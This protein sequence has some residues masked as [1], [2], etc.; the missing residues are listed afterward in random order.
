MSDFDSAHDR[1]LAPILIVDDSAT[2]RHFLI[3]S[4]APLADIE[5]IE[6]D[7]VTSAVERLQERI[8]AL[9]IFDVELPDGKGYDI[10]R[11]LRQNNQSPTPIIFITA[12]SLSSDQ[13][14]NAYE[15]GAVDFIHKPLQAEILRAKVRVFCDL[16]WQRHE[17]EVRGQELA[18]LS[19]TSKSASQAKSA[20]LANM[21]HE[22]RTPLN[23]I[24]GT[25]ELL[26]DTTLDPVQR[27]YVDIIVSS[28][29]SLL[30]I[31]ND[32]LDLSKIEAG[33]TKVAPAHIKMN[34]FIKSCADPVI[35]KAEQKE[36]EF[37][38]YIQPDAPSDFVADPV[39]LRQIVVNLL[40]NAVKFTKQG[41][42][43]LN[44]SVPSENR[45][46]FVVND[47]GI[48]IPND[49]LDEIFD[50]FSQA[51]ISTTRKFGGTG[52]GLAIT[53]HLTDMMGG[54]LGVTSTLGQGST[55]WIEIPS[56]FLQPNEENNKP[57]A[58]TENFSPNSINFHVLVVEDDEVNRIIA[59]RSLEKLGCRVDIAHHGLEGLEASRKL[60]YDIIFMDC[61]M[62]TM[63]GYQATGLI[64]E[65][66]NPNVKTPII[67]LTANVL[68]GAKQKCLDAGM[69]DYVSKPF[70]L[71]D[72]QAILEKYP[73]KD[74]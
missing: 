45:L 29:E 11:H 18:E 36:I 60:Q 51:D 24:I 44:V 58:N 63:D 52:L 13:I 3:E 38:L 25:A 72:L 67:A 27:R 23:G 12:A 73:K 56:T 65:H 61:M 68:D 14:K 46:R 37:V 49:K 71:R 32:I 30:T 5:L 4:L 20:F 8:Y 28:G 33:R 7:S 35:I 2:S 47:T 74:A 55:F 31:I 48:G 42:V 10:A 53:R 15:L 57:T 40:S 69:T 64:R 54:T 21:S 16:F 43:M 19:S 41:H 17:L 34:E 22:I 59:T 62:P 6:A 9:A 39:L 70:R 26:Q 1:R 66:N 50:A